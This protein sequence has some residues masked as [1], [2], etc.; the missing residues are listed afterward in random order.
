MISV[1]NFIDNAWHQPKSNRRIENMNPA[2]GE[3]F[4]SLPNSG[5]EDID[6]AVTAAK[7]AFKTWSNLPAKERSFFLK[8]IADLIEAR[9]TE[10]AEM[11][12][13][14]Q[15]KPITLA[16]NMDITRAIL[17]F[18]FFAEECLSFDKEF[19][20]DDKSKNYV[21]RK[22]VGVAG[23]ISPWNLP[24]YLLT[25]KI[26]PAIAAG[27]TVVC[28]PS[29]LT[30]MTAWLLCEV[31]EK[32]GLPK[33]VVNMVFGD[34]PNAGEALVK[35]PDVPIIS[36]TG[37][38]QTGRRIY[39]ESA[40][41]FK[42]L[43]LELGGKNPNLI[44]ADCDLEKTINTT[45]RSSFLNQGEICLCGSRI[46]V[47]KKIEKEFLAQFI[48]KTEEL[49]VGDPKDPKTF[50]GPVVSKMHL[51]KIESYIQ[52]AK[53]EGGQI[54]TGGQRIGTQGYFLKPTIIT[55]LQQNSACIQEEIFGPV[56][57]VNTFE[58]EEESIGLAN[59]VRYGLS[60]TVWS[61]DLVKAQRVAEHLDVGTVW[62]NTWLHRNLHMP[63]GGMKES[64]LGREGGQ[65]SMEFFS[66]LTTICL[67]KD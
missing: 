2:S 46:Y 31:I 15:G 37:G 11:E 4:S 58:T 1:A 49:I 54:Q 24:L 21:A 6:L 28:K 40:Q 66:E 61:K 12:S 34:G 41:H 19:R 45:I 32:S 5:K 30:S 25:W 17:N 18:R 29:E 59:D 22:P 7:V 16:K 39:Q 62:I 33:G 38:T 35:H 64:G 63:F 55:G 44:F 20:E 26:A 60:A 14:D 9:A 8:K 51:E 67:S 57:T 27:N 3:I 42:K 10:F 43:S 56:V 65:Y 23:L 47:E 13:R 52:K 53:E 36:F 48:K 50:M